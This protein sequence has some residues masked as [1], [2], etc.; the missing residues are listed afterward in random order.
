MR[1]PILM[2]AMVF[3]LALAGCEA[4]IDG[5]PTARQSENTE[6]TNER[7]ETAAKQAIT[8]GNTD[9]AL[10]SYEKLYRQDSRDPQTALNYAY[11]LRKTGN[12][13]RAVL[14]LAPFVDAKDKKSAD[15]VDPLILLEHASSTLEMG[16]FKEAEG[17]LQDMLDSPDTVELDPQILNLIGVS[18]DA[19]G[20]H[21]VAEEYYREALEAW[22]GQPIT[23]M[24]NLALNLTHQGYFDEALTLLRKAYVMA[25]ERDIIAANIDL[26]TDLHKNIQSKP[27]SLE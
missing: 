3:C 1:K 13:E 16:R 10:I 17:L 20:M 7:L 22:Q 23:V 21:T 11:V 12:A 15:P 18:M 26:V 4:H 5:Q 6:T 27:K 8:D 25:P 2:T 9:E 24:N 14:V 19:Q